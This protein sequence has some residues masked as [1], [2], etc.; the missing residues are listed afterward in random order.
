MMETVLEVS[1]QSV[2]ARDNAVATV[3]CQVLN[4]AKAA[5]EVSNLQLAMFHLVMTNIRP[6]MGSMILDELLSVAASTG[7]G[8]SKSTM[9]VWLVEGPTCRPGRVSG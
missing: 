3:F 8:I 2:I 5:Y 6:V 9:R 1:Q 4:A 7:G